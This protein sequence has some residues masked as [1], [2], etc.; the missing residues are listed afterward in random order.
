[1]FTTIVWEVVKSANKEIFDIEIG[2][3]TFRFYKHNK[4]IE[5]Y[6]NNVVIG[7]V[8][9]DGNEIRLKNFN[10]VDVEDLADAFYLL[11]TV[12]LQNVKDF[13]LLAVE[14]FGVK[15]VARLLSISPY[16]LTRARKEMNCTE[17]GALEGTSL[18]REEVWR[19]L[20][21]ESVI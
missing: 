8:P 18:S 9:Y 14:T 21:G 6:M 17:F 1:M 5:V 7:V 20:N 10:N 19:T 12:C 16:S 4:L 3:F 11:E 2:V 15:P 13:V